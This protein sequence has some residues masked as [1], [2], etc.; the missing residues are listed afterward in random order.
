[1]LDQVRNLE[2]R[3]SHNEAHIEREVNTPSHPDF[4]DFMSDM[5]AAGKCH[6]THHRKYIAKLPTL[7]QAA[8]S[9]VFKV[10]RELTAN[11]LTGLRAD[12]SL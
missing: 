6:E 3:F 1:M 10:P 11:A 8:P 5:A 9:S 4:L 12:F 2:N 7:W